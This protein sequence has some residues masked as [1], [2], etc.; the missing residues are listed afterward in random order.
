MKY[1][2]SICWDKEAH[3]ASAS[4]PMEIIIN[5]YGDNHLVTI[6]NSVGNAALGCSFGSVFG[7]FEIEE[8]SFASM[9]RTINDPIGRMVILPSPAS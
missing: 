9:L 5:I 8:I 1:E 3:L 6:V 2:C 4:E 7:L